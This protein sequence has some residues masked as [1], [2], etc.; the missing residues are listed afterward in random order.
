[1]K[2]NTFLLLAAINWILF[3]LGGLFV[4]QSTFSSIAGDGVT[5]ALLQHVASSALVLG[6]L[7][8]FTRKLTD[9][10]AR[11]LII[12]IFII[13]F[14]VS[15]IINGMGIINGI[16]PSFD[17]IFV[18]IDLIFAFGFAYFRFIKSE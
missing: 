18:G 6:L 9:P 15:A 11:R 7:A 4:P 5:N 10:D 2:L 16:Y 13:A 12:T 3:G 8:W 17:W 1:M 14:A